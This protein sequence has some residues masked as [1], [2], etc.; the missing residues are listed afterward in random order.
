MV[1]GYGLGQTGFY[2]ERRI[3]KYEFIDQIPY[4]AKRIPSGMDFGVSPDPTTLIDIWMKDNNLYC[5]EVFCENNLLPEK[6]AGAE[7][8]SIVD[9][10]DEVDHNKGQLIIADSAGKT[11]ILDIRKHKYNIKGVKKSAGSIV[12]S[13]NKLRGY[14]IFITIR[15]VNLKKGIESWF[16]KV[17]HNDKI[18]PE[19]HGH[20]PDGLAAIRYVA[21]DHDRFKPI[22]A[23]RR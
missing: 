14:N 23:K 11:E 10:L 22:T 2:S 21:M 12:P 4:D 1:Q 15:S 17:D 19:P 18:I 20:E 8:M 5:D 6:L 9:K 3:Y 13:I 7:R 16:W